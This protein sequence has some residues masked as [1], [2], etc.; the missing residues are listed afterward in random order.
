MQR[1]T[2]DFFDTSVASIAANTA[3]T[4]D[5]QVRLLPEDAIN[6]T[7]RAR[8]TIAA[9]ESE[10]N[11]V[12]YMKAG[13]AVGDQGTNRFQHRTS[14]NVASPSVCKG[15]PQSIDGLQGMYLAV[16]ELYNEADSNPITVVNVELMYWLP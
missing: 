16:D 13:P 2:V 1:V 14:L 12:A 4:T 5:S 7:V 11:V 8:A 10:D 9:A 15:V 6:P 3:Y